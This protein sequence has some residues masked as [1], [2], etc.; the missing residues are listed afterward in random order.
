MRINRVATALLALGVAMVLVPSSAMAASFSNPAPITINDYPVAM[1][2]S[3]GP[4]AG[5]STPY[6]SQI[7][8]SGL[9][10]PT[11]VTAT[12]HGFTHSYTAD[13]RMLLVG[14]H[15]QS[16]ELLSE[17]GGNSEVSGID[18]TFD[19]AAADPVPSPPVSGTFKPTQ[20]ITGC[21]LDPQTDFPSPAPANPYGT[22]LSGF[23]G[24]DPNGAWSLYT[25]DEANEDDGVITGGW[26]LD[27][28][29][30]PLPPSSTAKD[31]KCAK[32]RKKL[33]RQKLKLANATTAGKQSMI[34]VNI[35]DTKKRLKHLGC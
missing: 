21:T 18:L 25:V 9:G 20:D 14:P 31:P 34:R 5:Q 10:N 33:K 1:A 13:V 2:C 29:A 16:T 22:D 19:D 30:T 28:T 26:S 3:T 7:Q 27:I 32:L 12:L 8:V 23:N 17:V 35:A 11:H 24:I 6:P 4:D 15:G